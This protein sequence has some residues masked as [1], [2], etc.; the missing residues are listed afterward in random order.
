MT[1]ET[2]A[3][4][5]YYD[6]FSVMLLSDYVHGNARLDAAL[7]HVLSSIPEGATRVLELGC[8]VGVVADAISQH[9]P[10]ASVDALDL[11][12]EN[13]SNAIK[14]FASERIHFDVRDITSSAPLSTEKYDAVVMVDVL[15]HVPEQ[16]RDRLVLALKERMNDNSVFIATFPSPSF[17]N[18]LRTQSPDGLQPVDEDISSEVFEHIA[19][20]LGGSVDKFEFK[21]IWRTG[22]Y[23]HGVVTRGVNAS[24]GR[25]IRHQR[26]SS[27]ARFERV[28]ERLGVRIAPQGIILPERQAGPIAVVVPNLPTKSETFLRQHLSSLPFQ[29]HA[30]VA[31]PFWS[32]ETGRPVGG[33]RAVT[34]GLTFARWGEHRADTPLLALWLRAQK[35]RCV[36]AEYGPTAVSMLEACQLARVPLIA[37]FHGYDAY[38]S[39]TLHACR[40]GYRKLF[41]SPATIVAVSSAMRA[42]LISLGA[43][44]TR[45]HVIPCGADVGEA[46]AADLSGNPCVA[47]A[48]GRFVEKKGPWL[49]IAAFAEALKTVPDARLVMFGDGPLL[50]VC[51]D[52]SR[53]LGVADRIDFRGSASHATVLQAIRGARLFVQ[54][55]IV[56]ADGDCE[57]SPVAVVEAQLSGIPVVSTKHTGIV[58]AVEDGVTGFLVEE[59]D[60]SAMADRLVQL[61]ASPGRAAEMGRA[62]RERALSRYDSTVTLA[63][64]ADLVSQSIGRD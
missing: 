43:E 19:H 3:I 10:N 11:S 35:I 15:E 57:G 62:A 52:I 9:F 5:S 17:Q 61:F 39:Q 56:A 4:R 51:R 42:Q 28:K 44:P 23:V 14:L 16:E 27:R 12:V 13:V 41:A 40:E 45:I 59:R 32:D 8:G 63:A 20:L 54:H 47:V 50:P 2:G 60:V 53:V 6:A 58:D 34:K 25:R 30:L 37:H 48:V 24:A 38:Q 18:Y 36:V 22:D 55:S 21:T 31:S 49:T 7:E 1:M 46:P 64:L 33:L 26:G 29:T